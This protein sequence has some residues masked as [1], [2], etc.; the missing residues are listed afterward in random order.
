MDSMNSIASSAL[1]GVIA[2]L[3]ATAIL[4]AASYIRRR[5]ARRQAIRH[6]QH[7][8]THA[9][10][11]V[12]QA[13]EERLESTNQRIPANALRAAR[14]NAMLKE[15]E[16][17]LDKW[18]TALSYDQR[19]EIIEALDWYNLRTFSVEKDWPGRVKLKKIPDGVWVGDLCSETAQEKFQNLKSIKWLKLTYE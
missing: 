19:E 6:L 1:A 2:A 7:L 12:M 17:A 9:R 11:G 15:L 8:F 5:A 4:G 13:E 16:V 18:S 10:E 14:Y 3:T